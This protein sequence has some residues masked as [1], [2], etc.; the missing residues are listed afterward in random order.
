MYVCINYVSICEIRCVGNIYIK[1]KIYFSG[2]YQ[3][4]DIHIILDILKYMPT[5][6][7]KDM[8]RFNVISKDSYDII[9]KM[10]EIGLGPHD[11]TIT[12]SK[13]LMK[14][15]SDPKKYSIFKNSL[16]EI[17]LERLYHQIDFVG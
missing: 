3:Y 15:I 2:M 5:E 4:L 7:A 8:F 9:T 6:F 10:E 1:L 13:L 12:M 16:K 14:D 11:I 17:S